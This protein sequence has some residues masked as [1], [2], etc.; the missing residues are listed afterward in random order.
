MQTYSRGF[1]RFLS[2]TSVSLLVAL[3][4]SCE[5]DITESEPAK[6]SKGNR[7]KLI[8]Q[9]LIA[10]ADLEFTNSGD[11]IKFECYKEEMYGEIS[12][13]YDKGMYLRFRTVDKNGD[14]P[15]GPVLQITL[16]NPN[17]FTEGE[18]YSLSDD[19]K[20]KEITVSLTSSYEKPELYM[21]NN[22]KVKQGSGELK[23]ISLK[24]NEIEGVYNFEIKKLADEE[25]KVIITNGKFKAEIVRLI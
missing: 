3:I 10:S 14:E 17:G 22:V 23:I 7:D 2:L 5:N 16:R 12:I 11:V 21:A 1:F 15:D 8:S 4:F 18:V 19:S 25:N 9:P 13:Q 6:D 24:G 20:N